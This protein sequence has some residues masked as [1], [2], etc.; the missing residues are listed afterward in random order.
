MINTRHNLILPL[1]SLFILTG[2]AS[3]QPHKSDFVWTYKGNTIVQAEGGYCVEDKDGNIALGPFDMI[4]EGLHSGNFNNLHLYYS[5]GR[6]G[7]LSTLE[8]PRIIT[9]PIYLEASTF[10]EYSACVRDEQGYFYIDSDCKP[11]FGDR[12]FKEALPFEAQFSYARVDEDGDGFYD[13][14]NNKGDVVLHDCREI[15]PLDL[16]GPSLQEYGSA[17]SHDGTPFL[18][19]FT[20]DFNVEIVKE[21]EGF[22]HIG[23]VD[24]GW[25]LIENDLGEK[26]IVRDYNGSTIV[27]VGLYD[28]IRYRILLK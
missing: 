6:Y 13:L 17:I 5:D 12:R 1:I 14:I 15:T 10:E 22:T 18:Y 16:Y 25:A 3:A 21:F 4:D 20:H 7:F 24:D 2:C 19:H 11:L 9:P 8:E 23:S 26:G 28:D 27:P